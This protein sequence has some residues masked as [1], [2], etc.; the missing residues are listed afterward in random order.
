MK[1]RFAHLAVADLRQAH[2]D[3]ML[4]VLLYAPLVILG[5]LR[6]GLPPLERLL[7]SATSFDLG[8]HYPFIFSLIPMLM[9]LMVGMVVGFILLDE[10]DED[11]LTAVAVSSVSP[12]SYLL[13]KI[14]LPLLYSS[15]LSFASLHLAGPSVYPLLASVPGVLVA[16]LLAPT[17]A[18]FLAAFA[19]NKVTGLVLAKGAGL[20]LIFPI[21]GYLLPGY[22][23]FAMAPAPSFWISL[24]FTS[25]AADEAMAWPFLLA[26]LL[27]KTALLGFFVRRFERTAG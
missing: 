12:S 22:W 13:Y 15:M 17:V 23:S 27:G 20:I 24:H 11:I 14:L 4:E 6:F 5:L 3:P 26:G 8:P 9:P 25:L 19:E 1:A 2:R 21:A 16:S 7:L 10:R 18:F